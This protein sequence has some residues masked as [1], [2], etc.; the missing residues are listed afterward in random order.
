MKTY[1]NKYKITQFGYILYKKQRFCMDIRCR[2]TDC[3]YNEMLTCRVKELKVSEKLECLSYKKHPDK[4]RDISKEIFETTPQIASYRHNKD[5]CLECRADCL[6]NKSKNCIAN[7]ITVNDI[8][9]CPICITF[10]KK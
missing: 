1:K 3:E 6:F 5:L 7:G 10:M 9:D 2:K 8:K 4:A